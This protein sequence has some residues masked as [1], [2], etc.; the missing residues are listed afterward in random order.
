MGI[1][2]VFPSKTKAYFLSLVHLAYS[3]GYSITDSP[4]QRQYSLLYASNAVKTNC[5][6]V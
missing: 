1:K 5:S 4:R 6:D 2:D 3:M